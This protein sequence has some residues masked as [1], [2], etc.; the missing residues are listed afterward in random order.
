M[1]E[2]TKTELNLRIDAYLDARRVYKKAKKISDTLDANQKTRRR[3]LSEWMSE[4]QTQNHKRPDGTHFILYKQFTFSATKDNE[5]E[6]RD[7]LM[8]TEG[9][10]TPYLHEKINK[11]ALEEML[12]RK[13]INEHIPEKEFPDFLHLSTHPIVHVRSLTS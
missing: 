10:D 7:W 1:S 13:V 3:Q 6:I 11:T 8:K 9:D 12:K 5:Q 4:T 2:A